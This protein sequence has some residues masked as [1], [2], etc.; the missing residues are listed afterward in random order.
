MFKEK[1][2]RENKKRQIFFA[3]T[4]RERCQLLPSAKRFFFFLYWEQIDQ[5]LVKSASSIG[6]GTLNLPECVC[7]LKFWCKIWSTPMLWSLR[8]SVHVLWHGWLPHTHT[9][10]R[11]VKWK[12]RGRECR[13][14]WSCHILVHVRVCWTRRDNEMFLRSLLE[15]VLIFP[16]QGSSLALSAPNNGTAVPH[17]S[18]TAQ[19]HTHPCTHT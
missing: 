9:H 8:K 3:R 2:K 6:H 13:K 11:D 1:K 7:V 10:E 17:T 14:R 19:T 15:D 5:S 4:F 16:V 18:L 12:N